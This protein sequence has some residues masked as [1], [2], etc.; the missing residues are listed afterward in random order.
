V[1]EESEMSGPRSGA[2]GDCR[3]RVGGAGNDLSIEAEADPIIPAL[4]RATY[5][6]DWLK[7]YVTMFA[8]RRPN[9]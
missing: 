6:E 1:F 9:A 8:P 2:C 4:V 7:P 5:G 3:S